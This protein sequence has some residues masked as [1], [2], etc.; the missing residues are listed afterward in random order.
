MKWLV[1]TAFQSVFTSASAGAF[2]C[3]YRYPIQLFLL[4]NLLLYKKNFVISIQVFHNFLT[5]SYLLRFP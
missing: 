3:E 5:S 1:V 4:A 2:C